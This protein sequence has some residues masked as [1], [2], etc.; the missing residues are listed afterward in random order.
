ML[1]SLTSLVAGF[2]VFSVLGFMATKLN[3]DISVVAESGEP[4]CA[5]LLIMRNEEKLQV[6]MNNNNH[7]HNNNF[8]NYY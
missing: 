5:I 3:V 1:N 4:N 8:N 7:N 6:L 2:A